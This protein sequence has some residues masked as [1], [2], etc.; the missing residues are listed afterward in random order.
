MIRALPVLAAI[1]LGLAA[2]PAFGQ[3]IEDVRPLIEAALPKSG[4]VIAEYDPT[5]PNTTTRIRVGYDAATRA[6]FWVSSSDR[7]FLRDVKGQTWRGELGSDKTEL[8][9]N[10]PAI[11]S[12]IDWFIPYE[13]IRW[14]WEQPE[15]V[16]SVERHPDGGIVVKAQYVKGYRDLPMREDL[17]KLNGIGELTFTFDASGAFTSLT[18]RILPDGPEQQIQYAAKEAPP[19]WKV[20]NRK[21]HSDFPLTRLRYHPDG[22]PGLFSKEYTIEVADILVREA[23]RQ[24]VFRDATAAGSAV[25]GAPQ[26]PPASVPTPSPLIADRGAAAAAAPAPSAPAWRTPVL[27][28]SILLIVIALAAKFA[29]R[30][31]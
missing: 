7:Y 9:Q 6:W 27:I 30:T 29:R 3:T 17:I 21:S 11:S 19:G 14:L 1:L 4:S 2:S 12:A 28:A 10:E 8:I 18:S 16:T 25:P 23:S 13:R 5:D 24:V 26:V 20:S 31:P 22:A 15:R